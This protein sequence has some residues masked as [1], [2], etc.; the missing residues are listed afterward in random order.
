MISPTFYI[1]E[2]NLTK[3]FAFT[4]LS[5]FPRKNISKSFDFDLHEVKDGEDLFTISRIYFGKFGERFWT[6]LADANSITKPDWLEIGQIIKIP[7]LVVED[8]I[9]YKTTYDKNVSTAIKI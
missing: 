4:T 8:K 1:K 7:R 5:H 3:R 9:D 2:S 6:V